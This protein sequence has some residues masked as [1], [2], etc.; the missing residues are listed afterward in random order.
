MGKKHGILRRS[1]GSIEVESLFVVKRVNLDL[2][3]LQ[4][5]SR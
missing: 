1:V 5:S 3:A 4:N 2:V